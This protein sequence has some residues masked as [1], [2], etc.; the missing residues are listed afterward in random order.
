MTIEDH[1]FPYRVSANRYVAHCHVRLVRPGTRQG[2]DVTLVVSELA[3]NAGMSV[4]NA[5]EDLLPQIVYAYDLLPCLDRAGPEHLT[6]IEHW[7]PFSY[8]SYEGGDFALPREGREE[9]F[10]RVT[11]TY[12]RDRP[13]RIGFRYP[14]RGLTRGAFSHPVWRKISRSEVEALAGGELPPFPFEERPLDFG[15]SP[16][17]AG[18]EAPCP[19][20]PSASP[21]PKRDRARGVRGRGAARAEAAWPSTER[22][23]RGL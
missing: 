19:S 23:L 14:L 6:V 22:V 20:S 17:K 16:R 5:F 2:P 9:E 10:T 13:T 12:E 15:L 1:L 4:C 11:Y 7:G 21:S 3:S 18:A 8:R